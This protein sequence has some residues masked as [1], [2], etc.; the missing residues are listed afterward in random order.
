MPLLTFI[1][2]NLADFAVLG[3]QQVQSEPGIIVGP[4]ARVFGAI[5][6]FLFNI[7]Y[8][9]TPSNSLGFS[10]ILLTIVAM[11][12][13][14]PLGVK[15]QKSMMK[16]QQL[17]P[18]V[19]K[20]RAKYKDSKDRE[21]QQ[22]MSQEINA[23]YG[24]HKV[25]PLGG[26]LPML[27]QMPLFFGLLHI[28][29]Q[30]FLYIDVLNTLYY[31]ISVAVQAV[32][33]YL[34]ILLPSQEALNA[35]AVDLVRPLISNSWVNNATTIQLWMERGLTVEQAAIQ[36][37]VGTRFI[38][39]GWP[40]HLSRVFNSFTQE[41]WTALFAQIPDAYMYTIQPLFDQ[42]QR[43][44]VFFGLPLR[45]ASGWLPPGVLI[46]ILAV[47]TSLTSAWLSQQVNKPKD[48]KAKT[49]QTIML[50]VMP[51]FMGFI[52]ITMPAGV[53]LYWITM[54]LFRMVQQLVMNKQAGVKLT[55]PFKKQDA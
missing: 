26:C 12:I 7:A 37:D 2:A 18:E 40:E 39:L 48:E 41:S 11:V 49:Q 50:V 25:N 36:A 20:I 23:L 14:L 9:I 21:S 53:G 3:R 46:P 1:Q 24:K 52:T 22:K 35:G 47:L 43:I 55:L 54:N 42:L 27:I 13:M 31:D 33:Y 17:S 5:L 4:I 45:D 10:I 6:N 15:S 38:Y 8:A 16:M 34:D 29:N 30:S 44:E 19:E 51:L 32:P 28:M